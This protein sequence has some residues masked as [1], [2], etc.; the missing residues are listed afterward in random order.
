MKLQ[1]S[2]G[3]FL[4]FESDCEASKVHFFLGSKMVTSACAP[5]ASVPRPVSPKIFAGLDSTQL[6][7][8]PQRQLEVMMQDS[9]GDGQRGFQAGDAEGRAFE[10]D[11]LS[12]E[13]RAARGR[14]QWRRWCRQGC[15]RSG[16]RD[17]PTE[18]SGG[19]IL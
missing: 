14:W 11:L 2:N 18:R 7:N 19:F 8:A 15:P 12:R 5:S 16:R 17:R 9:E 1:P 10:L 3:V 13:R 4:D 6:D